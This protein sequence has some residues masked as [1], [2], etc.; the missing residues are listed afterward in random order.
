[1]GTASPE[2]AMGS[3]SQGCENF[4]ERLGMQRFGADGTAVLRGCENARSMKELRDCD[5]PIIGTVQD[6]NGRLVLQGP[7]HQVEAEPLSANGHRESRSVP[8]VVPVERN[9]EHAAGEVLERQS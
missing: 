5:A 6:H 2:P 8:R 4:V 3:A 1:M 7:A 9:A